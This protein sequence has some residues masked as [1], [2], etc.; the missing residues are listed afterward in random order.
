M[1]LRIGAGFL[2]VLGIVSLVFRLESGVLL[3][4]IGAGLLIVH[5]KQRK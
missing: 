1:I 3:V 2:I 5:D 4:I